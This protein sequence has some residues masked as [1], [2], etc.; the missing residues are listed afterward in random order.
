MFGKKPPKIRTLLILGR[1]SNLPTIWSDCLAGW[2]LGGGGRW[3]GLLG[4]CAATSF[5]YLGGMFLNDAFDADY[6]SQRRITR[7]IPAG[8]IT[9]VEVWRWG[10][11]LL[12]AG[13]C[14]V[15][16]D[17]MTALLLGLALAIAILV[18]D[19]VH[20][21]VSL[22]PLLM[23]LCRL[24]V[25]LIAASAG[26]RGVT[27]NAIWAGLALASYVVGL[28]FLAR[29]E[30]TRASIEYW[31]LLFLCAPLGLAWLVNGGFHQSAGLIAFCLACWMA[32]TLRH[33]FWMPDRNISHT[34][35]QL[36]AGVVIVDLLSVADL[37]NPATWIFPPLFISALILQRRIPAT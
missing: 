1:V 14:L 22:S 18:Y 16:M 26:A 11:S 32:W 3:P 24:L 6:D 23:G 8:L 2:W 12:A 27:G 31:P 34:V 36:L 37:S 4:A 28:S 5:F 19:A 35:S 33:A 21:A 10:L 17:G 29:K 13:L 7:P 20:K 15:A 30:T 25:Y 9:A